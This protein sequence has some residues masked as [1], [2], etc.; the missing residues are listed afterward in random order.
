MEPIGL[1]T[2]RSRN[3]YARDRDGELML[4]HRCTDCATI[5]INRIAADDSA[6]A[7]L[8]LFDG[9]CMTSAVLHAELATRGVAMLT[10]HDRDLVQRRLFGESAVRIPPGVM[11][12]ADEPEV[13]THTQSGNVNEHGAVP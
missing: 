1:T 6:A 12:S 8:A 7:I 5:V 13:V 4:V 3:K 2:K 10:V 9:S 11:L